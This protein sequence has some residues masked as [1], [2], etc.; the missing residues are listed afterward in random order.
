MPM[1][2][3]HRVLSQGLQD[4]YQKLRAAAETISPEVK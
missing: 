1:L 4:L 2:A 3:G